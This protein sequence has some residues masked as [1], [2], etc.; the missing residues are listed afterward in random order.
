MSSFSLSTA[1][2]AENLRRLLMVRGLFLLSLCTLLAFSYWNL[3]LALPYRPMLWVIS[4]LTLV[5]IVTLLQMR[6]QPR[7][8]SSAFGAQL[9]TDIIGITALLYFSG[10]ADNPFVSYYLVPLCMGAATLNWR[11]SWILMLFS[12][13]CYTLLFFYHIP[14]PDLAPHAGHAGHMNHSA[15]DSRGFSAHTIGMWFN[16]LVS[17]TLV[18]FFVVR[19]ADSLRRQH[20]DLTQ[21]KEDRLRDEQLLAVATL[22]A[23]TS[24]EL[25]T[26]LTTIK[27]LLHEM[28]DEQT[29]SSQLKDDLQ[30]LQNQVS[31]CTQALDNLRQQ[32]SHWSEDT[33]PQQN[34]AIY[35]QQLIDNWLLMR[36]EVNARIAFDAHS[37]NDQLANFHPS[38]SQ[39]IL[40][41]L[42]NAAD[43]NPE[44][45]E[46]I[47]TWN[48]NRL[49][50]MI[51]D[52]G[53]GIDPQLTQQLG[54][55]FISEKG[56][57]RGLGLFLTRATLERHKG[58]LTLDN[59]I[60]GGTE[61]IITLSLQGNGT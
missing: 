55:A 61:A 13:G 5:N 43:A 1:A 8:P 60:E 2:P 19:M 20:E 17:A 35:C 32:A 57:G 44:N 59:H 50:L 52:H 41:I 48:E 53:P 11:A 47:V 15:H 21:L 24:H 51:R 49:K 45:I 42:N 9:L 25:S 10:G 34:I 26:P 4:G 30:L 12:L 22:A 28:I 3:Q 40:N 56:Q 39:A 7:V 38:E 29:E 37:S 27:A 31:Q 36:P 33:Q 46:I 6:Y 18:T 16:F 58:T 14:L 54:E 23:G